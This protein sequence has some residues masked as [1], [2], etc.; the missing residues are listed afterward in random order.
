MCFSLSI[1]R[2]HGDADLGPF[3]LLNLTSVTTFVLY[4]KLCSSE[5]K[6]FV[7]L[8]DAL[9][10]WILFI[11]DS[12]FDFTRHLFLPPAHHS[13]ARSALIVA[14]LPVVVMTK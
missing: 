4:F 11:L 8:K 14:A 12:L 3:F 7:L 2:A 5:I 1:P 10:S 9:Y 13:A 6:I